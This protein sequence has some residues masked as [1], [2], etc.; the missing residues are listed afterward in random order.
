MLWGEPNEF[1]AFYNGFSVKSKRNLELLSRHVLILKY[2]AEYEPVGILKLAE[3]T[4][5][6]SHKVRYS[7]GILEQEGLIVASG[8]GARTT[9]ETREFLE[10]LGKRMDFLVVA[11]Q[12]IKMLNFLGIS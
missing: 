10:S 7:L 3:K 4:K 8:P 11:A 9:H 6:P 1:Q 12:N 2:V 5:I